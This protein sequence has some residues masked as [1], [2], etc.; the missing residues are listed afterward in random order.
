M[1]PILDTQELNLEQSLARLKSVVSALEPRIAKLMERSGNAEELTV[2]IDEQQHQI[3]LLKE[4]VSALLGENAM[5]QT[6]AI[7]AEQKYEKLERANKN[8]QV[9]VE[10]AISDL[11]LIL[12]KEA[13]E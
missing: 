1:E 10:S 9:Q 6:R 5:L 7:D 4:Q 3:H 11:Q 8:A 12:E 2:R 13:A